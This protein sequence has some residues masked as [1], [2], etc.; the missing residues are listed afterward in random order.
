MLC[1]T[2][3][4]AAPLLFHFSCVAPEPPV[5]SPKDSRQVGA[6]AAEFFFWTSDSVAPE[7]EAGVW[8]KR[9][10]TAPDTL[11]TLWKMICQTVINT[12]VFVLKGQQ[13]KYDA[14]WSYT[15]GDADVRV[16]CKQAGTG[17]VQC[18]SRQIP[19]Q[20]TAWKHM[21]A[22]LKQE[23]QLT[24]CLN[25]GMSRH[26]GV[27]FRTAVINTQG[28]VIRLDFLKKAFR[29]IVQYGE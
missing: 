10:S 13:Q 16:Y 20:H 23:R 18:D 7:C 6:E 15:D 28:G 21:V 4:N 17:E 2:A 24:S 5:T 22:V 14:I 3:V 25:T 12:P 11:W 19:Q 26:N 29:I 9:R 8:R 1:D 27:C